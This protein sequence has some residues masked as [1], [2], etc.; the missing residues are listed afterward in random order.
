[1]CVHWPG[2]PGVGSENPLRGRWP[3]SMVLGVSLR[4]GCLCWT[5][6]P[7]GAG[8]SSVLERAATKVLWRFAFKHKLTYTP[9]MQQTVIKELIWLCLLPSCAADAPSPR[10]QGEDCSAGRFVVLQPAAC[11]HTP[12]TP[13][14]YPRHMHT[15]S[16]FVL[17]HLGT[18]AAYSLSIGTSAVSV[19]MPCMLCDTLLRPPSSLSCTL[20]P[21]DWLSTPPPPHDLPFMT[22]R[23]HR[24]E[25][26]HDRGR[27]GGAVDS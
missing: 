5:K 13:C 11:N 16:T 26:P 19:C 1:M 25:D 23:Y 17:S 2:V 18:A 4:G 10:A 8:G 27:P 6:A 14:T 12:N 24:A 7:G 20:Q 21:W 22:N 3:R 9:T 15:H